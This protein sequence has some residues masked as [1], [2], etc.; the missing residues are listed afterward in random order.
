[1]GYAFDG[2]LA[3]FDLFHHTDYAV[4]PL[5]TRRR[6]VTLYDT[7][8]RADL[9]WVE[10]RQ[11]RRMEGA[12]RQLLVGDPEIVVLSLAARDELVSYLRLD[13]ARVHVTPLAADPVFAE[14]P[15]PAVVE[16][17]Q[18]R[19]D[20]RA[21]YVIAL[22]TLE[23]RKNLINLAR[24]VHLARRL[25]PDLELVLLGRKGYRHEELGE[26]MGDSGFGVT[27]WLGSVPDPDAVALVHGSAAL[28]FPSRHEGF[29]L[30]AIE[31][32]SAGVPV[33][34][35]DIPVMREICGEGALLV[36][37]TKPAPLAD[38]ILSC[39]Q[40]RAAAADLAAKGRARSAQ[41]TW[42]RC[43]ES[44]LAAYRALLARTS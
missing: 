33:I 6:V 37:T 28:G 40:D 43:A 44:T 9:G 2:L 42:R 30:P 24:G 25:V 5:R 13:P 41:F 19:Y 4:T 21:P 27:R 23:P 18:K 32:M 22:G 1:V 20:V 3:P 12:V 17:V 10:P 8:W 7:A 11:S 14:K 26:E 38:A 29:G 31:G 34:A 39:V 15:P 36:D 16:E 35:S